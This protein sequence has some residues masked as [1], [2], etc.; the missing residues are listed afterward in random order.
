MSQA[1]ITPLSIVWVADTIQLS[2]SQLTWTTIEDGPTGV[3]ILPDN[4]APRESDILWVD[5][6]LSK[7]VSCKG[8]FFLLSV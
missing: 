3:V 4:K 5:Q 1:Y 6:L 2:P 8:E 7:L